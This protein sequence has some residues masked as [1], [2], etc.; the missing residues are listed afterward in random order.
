MLPAKDFLF[1]SVARRLHGRATAPDP[2][3]L[4]IGRNYKCVCA[5]PIFFRNSQCL[6][7]GTQL[8]YDP[9]CSW[10]LPLE[11]GPSEGTW[12]AIGDDSAQA[13]LF[14]RCANLTTA[15]ACN[16]L[17]DAP[18]AGSDPASAPL[19]NA[20]CVACRLN[21]TIPDQSNERFQEWWRRIEVAKRRMVSSLLLLGLPVNSRREDPQHGLEFDLLTSPSPVQKVLTG[22]DNGLI[23]IN[24][25]EADDA[26]RERVREAMHEPYRTLLG[27]FRHEIGHYYWDLLIAPSH[28]LEEFRSLFGDEQQDY[29]AALKRNYEQGPPADWAL[30]HVSTYAASHPWEDW[31]ETWAHYLHMMD[32]MDTALGF[33]IDAN[34][35]EQNYEPFT[36]AA[37]YRPEDPSAEDFIA[38]VNAWVRL[39]GMMN[40]LARSMGQN[41]LYPFVLPVAAVAKLHFVHLVVTQARGQ[42]Q[43]LETP[44]LVQQAVEEA[45]T[46]AVC[47][48]SPAE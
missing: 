22:H 10:L 23:T 45:T 24:V 15:A 38:F 47:E 27:H 3:T 40:E 17:V 36:T 39:T 18:A 48:P 7:C 26:Q 33:G 4:D 12:K 41:D 42:G 2:D 29:A 32:T 9:H 43:P 37:L 44:P 16:W 11:P 14:H 1:D 46:A 5:R 6:N 31:A 34:V 20:F 25:E 13:R 30:H 21:R 35:S 19:A 8:G 28:W